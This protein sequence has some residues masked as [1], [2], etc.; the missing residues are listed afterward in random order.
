MADDL[1]L[2][3]DHAVKLNRTLLSTTLFGFVLGACGPGLSDV[4]PGEPASEIQEQPLLTGTLMDVRQVQIQNKVMQSREGPQLQSVLRAGHAAA[5][6]PQERFCQA[7]SDAL[8]AN[9][10]ACGCGQDKPACYEMAATDCEGRFGMIGPEVQASADQDRIV[11]DG[12]AA[13]RFI[14]GIAEGALACETPLNVLGWT[15]QDMLTFGGIFRGTVA[16]GEACN[17]PFAPFRANE[18]LQG[19][20]LLDDTNQGHCVQTVDIGDSCDERTACF[21][22]NRPVEIRDFY[23]D[24]FAA[25]CVP[26][27]DGPSVCTMREKDGERCNADD[28]CLSGRCEDKRCVALS[29]HGDSCRSDLDCVQGLCNSGVCEVS[30]LP[31]G[32]ECVRH[33]ECSSSACNSGECVEPICRR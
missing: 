16:P 21:N 32:A 18:C 27:L 15:R 23:A 19:V 6:V 3:G 12:R 22:M 4:D 8:C 10:E 13:Y 33:A 1:P 29:H 31:V 5:Y 7:L 20:C 11:Y 14:R 9:L 28:A 2:R 26:A 17:L 30:D 24:T 25:R